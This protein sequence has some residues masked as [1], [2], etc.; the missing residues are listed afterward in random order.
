MAK[1]LTSG[2]KLRVLTLTDT[3]RTGGGAERIAAYIAA[4]LDRERFDSW[5]CASRPSAGLLVDYVRNADV[6][7]LALE[8]RSA[9]DLLAWRPLLSLLRRESIDVLHAHT[10]SSNIW[11]TLI[12]RIARV[13]VI[14]SHEHTWSYVGQPA[15]R[16]LDR[17]L[18]ARGSSAF[19]AVS[20]A[21]QRKMQ[22]VEK[23]PLRK[24]RFMP[25]GILPV[26]V[27]DG[28]RFRAELE[29]PPDALLVG[30][31]SVLRAQKALE[32]LIE[33]ARLLAPE[34]PALR[35]VIAG[36]GPEEER[37]RA[38]ASGTPVVLAGHRRD[39]PDLLAALDVAAQSSDFE[40]SP[41]AVME[42]MAA[43]LPVVATAVGGVPDLI[44]DDVHGLLV[45]PRD[46]PAL[47]AGIARLLRDEPLRR[48]LGESARERQ[49]Q[50]FDAAS[51]VRRFEELYEELYARASGTARRGGA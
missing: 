20:R 51:M 36:T 21:D 34:F 32:V 19:V 9:S 37:L 30:T 7:F 3:L 14:V 8:R 38:L 50:E 35:V 25:N 24:T 23:I 2:R 17:H 11:G 16:L 15:R 31:V 43:A 48:R 6:E 4:G 46:A 42:Y 22:E 12:G 18:I 27:G 1:G 26:T 41:L 44:D 47:A 39:V 29:I 49:R 28:R 13:P 10:F 33:A 40:G 45:P 5:L